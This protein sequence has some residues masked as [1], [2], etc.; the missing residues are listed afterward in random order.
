[1]IATLLPL[2]VQRLR[3]APTLI[4]GA[5]DFVAAIESA[6]GVATATA[7][8][9]AAEQAQYDAALASAHAALQA[10]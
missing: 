4:S 6:W 7:A 2:V 5:E 1:M 10:S 9:T 8:P 3:M